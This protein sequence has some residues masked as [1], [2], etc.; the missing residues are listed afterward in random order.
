MTTETK[1]NP[2]ASA[3]GDANLMAT[4]EAYRHANDARLAEIE[5][6]GKADP[7]TDERLARIDRR[8]EALSLKSATPAAAPSRWLASAR[9]PA[10]A[11]RSGGRVPAERHSRPARP[12]RCSAT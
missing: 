6:R 9:R 12:C 7:L 2:A 3:A 4:F 5:Q 1:M 8:L 11:L 10:A